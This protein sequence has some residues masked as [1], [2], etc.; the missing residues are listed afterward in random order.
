[1]AGP[2][3]MAGGLAG[4]AGA[5]ARLDAEPAASLP[6]LDNH[7]RRRLIGATTRLPYRPATPVIGAGANAVR[8]DF[9]LCMAIPERSLL[10]AFAAALERLLN[11]ALDR[12][13]PRPL[14]QPLRLNDAIVQRYPK[15]SFGIT[16]HRDHIRYR[17]LVALV[18]L[19]GSARFCLCDDRAGRG[20]RELP[21]PPGHLL[22]MRAP[23]FSFGDRGGRGDRPFHFL[24]R[25]TRSRLSLGLRHDA[26]AGQTAGQSAGQSD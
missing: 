8:Q 21:C 16:A 3:A 11:A 9:E 4:L 12:L 25:V 6:L 1:M 2:A 5:L 15:G 23:G 18:T 24:D 26:R 19:S 17:D 22:L 14:G 7:A 13:E 20:A 10:R